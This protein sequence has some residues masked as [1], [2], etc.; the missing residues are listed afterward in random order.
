[1]FFLNFFLLNNILSN[2]SN[3]NIN[4]IHLFFKILFKENEILLLKST[5]NKINI[6]E[7]NIPIF[8]KVITINCN[9]NL[10]ITFVIT[11]INITKIST[12]VPIIIRLIKNGI[13]KHIVIKTSIINKD[14]YCAII[15]FILLVL[16]KIKE[17]ENLKS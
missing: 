17:A 15:H 12:Y 14:I 5:G 11:I 4:I 16:K 8:L 9:N 13:I 3:M 6:Q 7:I 1:M 10:S 2:I